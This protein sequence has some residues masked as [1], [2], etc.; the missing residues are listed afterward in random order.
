MRAWSLLFCCACFAA[1]ASTHAQEPGVSETLARDRASRVTNVRYGL[2][3][4][5]PSDK[6]S[7]ISGHE[8]ITFALTEAR[9]PVA[10][11]FE[12]GS[13]KHVRTL[14]IGREQLP[15]AVVNGHILLP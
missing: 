9:R 13:S 7:N 11:D 4:S 12:P 8:V 6:T 3:F 10:L 2:F 5:I 15:P 14:T 1:G